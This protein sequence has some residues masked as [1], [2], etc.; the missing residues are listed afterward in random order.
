MP[1]WLER[2]SKQLLNSVPEADLPT[3]VAN[4]IEEPDLSAV[5]GFTSIYWTI[6]GDLVSL[7][8]PAERDATDATIAA[9]IVTSNRAVAVA[10]PDLSDRID[11]RAL[12][13]LLNKRDN[14]LTNRIEELQQAL[15]AV[16]ASAGPAD[17]IRAAIPAFW[18]VTATR[19]RAAAITDYKDDINAGN[20][21]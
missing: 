10:L 6:T 13:E 1:R 19:T 15:D 14:Y 12:I 18:L 3:S 11:V 9:A 5:V 17:N 2:T 20:A 8:S 16:K 4:W 21:D 7:Q